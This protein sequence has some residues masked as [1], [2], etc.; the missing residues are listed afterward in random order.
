M[1]PADVADM[2]F[3]SECFGKTMKSCQSIRKKLNSKGS[4]ATAHHGTLIARPQVS[5]CAMGGN[6]FHGAREAC[7]RKHYT[8]Y[9][10]GDNSQNLKNRARVRFH[11]G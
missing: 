5:H 4:E 6:S 10:A 1:E 7:Y 11:F 9:Q 2:I 8:Q 3:V